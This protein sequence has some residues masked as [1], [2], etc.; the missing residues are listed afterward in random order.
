M[1]NTRDEVTTSVTNLFDPAQPKVSKATLKDAILK[2]VNSYLNKRSDSWPLPVKKQENT[3]VPS[4]ALNDRYLVGS[5]PTGAWAGHD[6]TIAQ[7]DGTAWVFSSY[8]NGAYVLSSDSPGVAYLKSSGVFR[9]VRVPFAQFSKTTTQQVITSATPVAISSLRADLAA[10]KTYRID[11]S[12][13]VKSDSAAQGV[14]LALGGGSSDALGW[15]ALIP[16]GAFTDE[17][18]HGNAFGTAAATA[19]VPV[20]DQP[21][22][23]RINAV[24]VNTTSSFTLTP[25]LSGTDGVAVVTLLPGSSMEATDIT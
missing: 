22:L 5:A 17:V 20:A 21:F 7:W 25:L 8:G 13:L 2:L 4:P 1:D 14:K 15:T 3:P 23:I 6:N 10:G 9:V 12:L 18:H 11:V 19:S 16:T 24:V